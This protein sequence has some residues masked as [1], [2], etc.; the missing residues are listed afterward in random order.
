VVPLARFTG[1]PREAALQRAWDASALALLP[2]ESGSF[3][4]VLEDNNVVSGPGR[5]VSPEFEVRFPALSELYRNIEERQGGAQKSL[6]K[7]AEQARELQKTLDKLNREVRATTTDP[8]SFEKSE[9][10][11]SALQRQAEL[12]QQV[13]ASVQQVRQSLEM[14]A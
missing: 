5:A 11:K 8:G 3:R 10:L 9:E 6:E 7:V 13:D 14:A 4:L 2:G 1:A 12:S